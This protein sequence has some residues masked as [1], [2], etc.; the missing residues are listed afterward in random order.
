[1]ITFGFVE[2]PYWD[3]T[4][5]YIVG[6]GPSLAGFDFNRLRGLGH[7]VG[8][9]QSIWDAPSECGVTVDHPFVRNRAEQLREYAKQRP[10]YLSVG[11]D[12]QKSGLPSIEDATYLWSVPTPGLSTECEYLHKGATSGYAALGI[13]VLKKTRRIFLLGFDY[14]TINSRHHY[15]NN[16]PWHHKANDQSWAVWARR[17]EPAARDCQNLGIEV[18]NCSPESELPYFKKITLEES[19]HAIPNKTL[20]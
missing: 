12:W 13:A 17:Y 1:M 16:H 18:F 4:P 7:I 9:N 20:V 10:L 19:L 15:H 11:N 14:K 5:T 2:P 6:G 8:V 3:D